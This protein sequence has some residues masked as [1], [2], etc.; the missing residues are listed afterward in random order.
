MI[1]ISVTNLAKTSMMAD[2][3]LADQNSMMNVGRWVVM[4]MIIMIMMIMMM[5]I[6]MMAARRV[7]QWMMWRS[8][9][10]MHCSS[11]CDP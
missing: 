7:R 1:V 8:S 3:S 6:M 2:K 4:I 5:M 9:S 10:R 11:R